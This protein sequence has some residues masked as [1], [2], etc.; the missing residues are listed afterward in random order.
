MTFE[1]NKD[2]TS[3]RI[4]HLIREKIINL[5][6]VPG[7]GISEKGISEKF[8]VSRT[9]VREAF[10][11]LAQE[12][13]ISIYPQKG[14]FVSLINLSSVEEARFMREHLE[15]A[16]VRLAC[17]G[18]PKEMFLKLEMNLK[19]QEMYMEDHDNKK[20]FAA[21]E[22]FHRLIFEG[23]NK[24]KIWATINEMESDF[25][26]IRILRLSSN[27]KWDHIYSQ[28]IGIKNAIIDKNPDLAEK[29]I[30]EHLTMVNFDKDQ[31]KHDYSNYF[32]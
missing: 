19:F 2:S 30:I 28:H 13:L 23:C 1:I 6:F 27:L 3:K 32:K 25:Q 15:R 14:T 11:R 18:F 10:V 5:N 17:E 24:N 20:I 9:P 22:E 7:L 12:G 16:V 31:L 8:N 26:R 21:D 29:I 4:Y